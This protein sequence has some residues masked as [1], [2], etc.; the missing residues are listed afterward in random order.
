MKIDLF[1]WWNCTDFSQN[2][3]RVVRRQNVHSAQVVWMLIG[4]S[5]GGVRRTERNVVYR[6]A[7]VIKRSASCNANSCLSGRPAEGATT[8]RSSRQKRQ[9]NEW[10]RPRTLYRRLEWSLLRSRWSI[11]FGRCIWFWHRSTKWAAYA[12]WKEKCIS[13]HH[14]VYLCLPLSL[15]MTHRFVSGH[16]FQRTA[17]TDSFLPLYFGRCP[18][19]VGL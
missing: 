10:T 1:D 14:S 13:P 8:H 17:H 18:L 19:G 2:L 5:T 11:G 12:L 15:H 16:A 9:C 7:C 4:R 6:S 3:R